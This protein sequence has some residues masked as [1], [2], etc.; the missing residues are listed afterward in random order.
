MKKLT[1]QEVNSI[2]MSV[3]P[4]KCVVD[5]GYRIIHNNKVKCWVGIGWV[6]EKEEATKVDYENIPVVK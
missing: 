3:N 6:I 2:I 1:T 4:P 5:S